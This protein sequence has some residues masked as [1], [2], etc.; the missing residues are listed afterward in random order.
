[1]PRIILGEAQHDPRPGTPELVDGLVI[2]PHHKEVVLREGQH[3]EDLI[4]DPVHILELIHEDIAEFF[5]PPLSTSGRVLKSFQ[6]RSSISSK[7]IFLISFF[8][9]S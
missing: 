7:S 2:V 8:F 6:H 5:L 4:L 1:M 3:P 9:S